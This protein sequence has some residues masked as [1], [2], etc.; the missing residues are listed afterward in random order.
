MRKRRK[1]C[2]LLFCVLLILMG[3]WWKSPARRQMLRPSVTVT[4]VEA[5]DILLSV[6]FKGSVCNESLHEFYLAEPAYVTGVYA[7]IGNHVK[8]GDLLLTARAETAA[9]NSF[10]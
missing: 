1:Y 4:K 7:E 2:L 6:Y 8:A 10:P 9:E 5:S 3:M